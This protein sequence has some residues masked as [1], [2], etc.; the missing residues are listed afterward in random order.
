MNI[1][2]APESGQYYQQGSVSEIVVQ[3]QDYSTGDPILLQA[4]TGMTISLVYPDGLTR[5]DFAATLFTDGA[6]G[7]IKYRT[8]NNGST[9]VDLSQSGLY[10]VQGLAYIGGLP[11]KSK[12][13]D[14]YVLPD[15]LG[16]IPTPGVQPSAMIFRDTADVRWAMTVDTAGGIHFS[17]T[18]SGP[19][20]YTELNTVVMKDPNGLY[21]IM[22]IDTSG[23]PQPTPGGSHAGAL[24]SF[25]LV[26]SNNK[27]WVITIDETGVWVA[28]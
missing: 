11:I 2:D 28:S 22:A 18:P 8:R 25:I 1:G 4:A 13:T 9:L 21:W 16:T 6:D 15:A 27:S 12:W 7:R 20:S 5:Q 26:D 23:N 17:A 19:S 10:M 3:I 24:E 14:F